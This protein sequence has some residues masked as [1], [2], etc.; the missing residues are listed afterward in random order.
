MDALYS[1]NL[2]GVTLHPGVSAA[3]ATGELLSSK[4]RDAGHLAK[5]ASAKCHNRR[6][7]AVYEEYDVR[8]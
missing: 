6:E 8:E 2:Q 1:N 5:K 3:I 7:V 4:G